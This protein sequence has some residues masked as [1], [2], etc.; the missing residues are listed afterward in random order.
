MSTS[1]AFQ[2]AIGMKKTALPSL[3]CFI[4]D[5]DAADFVRLDVRA[6]KGKRLELSMPNLVY[7]YTPW[8]D[9]GIR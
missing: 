2:P 9:L 8:Q 6:L 4:T 7:T 5:A 3:E 1:T